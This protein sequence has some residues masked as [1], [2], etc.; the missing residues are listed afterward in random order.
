VI[1]PG[2]YLLY[3]GQPWH[4]QLEFIARTLSSHRANQPWIMRR[5]TQAELDQLVESAGF[6]K[7]E[8]LTDRWGIFTVSVAQRVAAQRVP[9]QRD[10]A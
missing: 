6:R 2:G 5:R 1:E 9:A 4:P 3:T 8:Q 10:A 7:V